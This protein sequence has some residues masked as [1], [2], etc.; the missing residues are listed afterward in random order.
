VNLTETNEQFRVE[1]EGIAA[2]VQHVGADSF[3]S[4]TLSVLGAKIKELAEDET[5]LS[6]V[7][8]LERADFISS[9]FIGSLLGAYK[10]LKERTCTLILCNVVKNV[11]GVLQISGLTKHFVIC[12]SL[13]EARRNI[14][15][16]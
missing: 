13:E 4:H 15:G 7:V 3:D 1:R 16:S 5:T 6:L 10:R 8:N 11:L 12:G 14:A 2:I 9:A